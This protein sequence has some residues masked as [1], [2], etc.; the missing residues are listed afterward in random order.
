[1][2]TLKS[3]KSLFANNLAIVLAV[4]LVAGCASVTD[5]S[6]DLQQSEEVSSETA[7]DGTDSDPIWYPTNRDQMDPIID[8]PDDPEGN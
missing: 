7:S 1:M 2:E 6:Q 8:E 5:A 4:T 3:L